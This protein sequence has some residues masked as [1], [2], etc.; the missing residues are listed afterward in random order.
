MRF[1]VVRMIRSNMIVFF[2]SVLVSVFVVSILLR[3]RVLIFLFVSVVMSLRRLLV[4]NV[5]LSVF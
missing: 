4:I 5:K 3:M 2:V 1:V